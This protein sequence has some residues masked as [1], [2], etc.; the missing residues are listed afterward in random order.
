ML[1][2]RRSSDIDVLSKIYGLVSIPFA[3]L[4]TFGSPWILKEF[5]TGS[6]HPEHTYAFVVGVWILVG[7]V[8]NMLSGFTSAV[9][10]FYLA[11]ELILMFELV[12]LV[13]AG[14][15]IGDPDSLT[16]LG[17]SSCGLGLG[18]ILLVNA[19]GCRYGNRR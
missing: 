12:F 17:G 15:M 4:I 1:N 14:L 5:L 8:L 10:V 18:A 13:L 11:R 7:A 19:L 3:V 16:F 2:Q 9:S 6:P